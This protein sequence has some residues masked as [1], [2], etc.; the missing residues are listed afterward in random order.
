MLRHLDLGIGLGLVSFENETCYYAKRDMYCITV[1]VT[2]FLLYCNIRA[3]LPI[4]LEGNIQYHTALTDDAYELG[5]A[6][7]LG[8]E[9]DKRYV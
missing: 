3:E 1:I 4:H 9:S 2:L 7:I 6:A 5:F 8:Q